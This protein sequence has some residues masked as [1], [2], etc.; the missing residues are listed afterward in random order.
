MEYLSSFRL[1]SETFFRSFVSLFKYCDLCNNSTSYQL[2]LKQV[3][4]T[5]LMIT[6]LSTLRSYRLLTWPR[7]KVYRGT[8]TLSLP[9]RPYELTRSGSPCTRK[10]WRVFVLASRVVSI[11]YSERKPIITLEKRLSMRNLEPRVL[12]AHCQRYGRQI[13]TSG[14]WIFCPG[15]RGFPVLTAHDY[16]L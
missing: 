2:V 9:W 15:N 10:S 12:L 14:E 3:P 8:K 16:I 4:C 11:S 1:T 6:N 13:M 5:A 7:I